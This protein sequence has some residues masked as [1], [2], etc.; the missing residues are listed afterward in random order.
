MTNRITSIALAAALATGIATGASAAQGDIDKDSYASRAVPAFSATGTVDTGPVRHLGEKVGHMND[1]AAFAVQRR[2][3]TSAIV[4]VGEKNHG[5]R[6]AT[7]RANQLA[8]TPAR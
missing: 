5:G 1:Q 6:H 7:G 3:G 2:G 4:W 8:K